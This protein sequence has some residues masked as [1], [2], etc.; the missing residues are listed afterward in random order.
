MTP[1]AMIAASLS[2]KIDRQDL[3]PS[4]RLAILT[5]MRARLDQAEDEMVTLMRMDGGTWADVG[6]LYGITRQ[7]A[8]MKFSDRPAGTLDK[9]RDLD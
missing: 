7:A 3:D 2:G 4:E 9:L 5:A 1:R 6:A 8:Q